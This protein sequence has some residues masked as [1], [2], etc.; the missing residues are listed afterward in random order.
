[1]SSTY[2]EFHLKTGTNRQ[3]KDILTAELAEAGF[4]SFMDSDEGFLAYVQEDEFDRER[5]NAAMSSVE[6]IEFNQTRIEPQNWNA[7][8]ESGFEPV[9]V[10]PRL[11]IRAS[12]HP[13][14]N[15]GRTEII[16]TPKMSFGTGHHPTTRLMCQ[17]LESMDL[18]GKRLLDMGC[19]TG[20]L[21][22]YAG[23]L[24]ANG[25]VGI[26]TEEWAVENSIENAAA[27]GVKAGFYHGDAALLSTMQPFDITLAN[28]NKNILLRDMPAYL[29]VL[30]AGG[31]LVLSGILGP[32][33]ADLTDA[34]RN[35]G[36][37]IH[38]E[39]AEDTWRCLILR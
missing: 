13:P 36:L 33:V 10:S 21:A 34:A 12:F 14:A 29:K 22:I 8:W 17:A 23:L 2:L 3:A 16:I 37:N 4:E 32:D 24:G 11:L 18:R 28:I 39:F 9:V 7:A 26:D 30:K 35:L 5:F 19:G 15:D 20:I 31:T 6:G 38:K 1:M 25:L 27:N